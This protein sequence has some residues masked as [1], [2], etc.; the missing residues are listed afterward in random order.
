[1]KEYTI[2]YVNQFKTNKEGQPYLSK[3][4]KPFVRVSIKVADHGEEYIS[5]LWFGEDCP[6]KV[7]DTETLIIFEELYNGKKQLKFELPK[8]E[9]VNQKVL[10]DILNKLTFMN[11]KIEEILEWKR[12]VAGV[13][14]SKI[15]GTDIDYPTAEDEGLT[16][17]V[18]F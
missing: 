2:N 11:L 15:A 1:M 12:D 17:E 7:G 5:G 18:P 9:N 8:K 14:K 3:N 10:E 16:D 6:W 4:G 13:P